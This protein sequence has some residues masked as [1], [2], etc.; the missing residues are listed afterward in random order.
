MKKLAI[1]LVSVGMAM[2]VAG[3]AETEGAAKAEAPSALTAAVESQAAARAAIAKEFEQRKDAVRK[4]FPTA[5]DAL[6]KD[7]TNRGSLDSVLAVKNERDRADRPLTPEELAKLPEPLRGIRLKYDQVMAAFVPEQRTRDA[8]S[9]RD[10]IAKL[11]LLKK[12]TTQ[13]GDIDGALK[14]K[15]EAEKART[16]LIAVES[17]KQLVASTPAAPSP[18]PAAAAPTAPA[19]A[20]A[21]DASPAPAADNAALIGNWHFRWVE[22]GYEADFT[23]SADGTFTQGGGGH[24]GKWHVDGNKIVMET[25]GGADKVISLPIDPTGTKVIDRR[26]NRNVNAVKLEAKAA[27]TA[28]Q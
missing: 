12:S 4:W 25:A 27:E 22:T 19:P 10:Y 3:G 7:A 11:D 8:A 9:I 17:G 18:E 5:L 26:K 2:R 6:E 21:A 13:R 1:I 20:P 23:F 28:T 14:I 16:E 24:D 15:D